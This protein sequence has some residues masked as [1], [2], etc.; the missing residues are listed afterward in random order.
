MEGITRGGVRAW[1]AQAGS[2]DQIQLA[3]E[4]TSAA[5]LNIAVATAH[6]RQ[7]GEPWAKLVV[8][9]VVWF[10]VPSGMTAERQQ[11]SQPLARLTAR[12]ANP[13]LVS[14]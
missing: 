7:D 1:A 2:V 14:P 5:G 12:K 9:V 4:L 6:Y 3:P 10:D 13:T 11:K 8:L